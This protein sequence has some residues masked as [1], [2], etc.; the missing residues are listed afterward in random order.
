MRSTLLR[1][2]FSAIICLFLLISCTAETDQFEPLN[3]ENYTYSGVYLDISE[4]TENAR[5]TFW[6][7]DGSRIFVTG[8]FTENV[9]S[10]DLPEPW[11]LTGAVF[12][13][14]FDLSEEFG[15]TTGI[16][17]AHGLYFRED[18]LKKWVFNRTEIWAYTL[19][20]PWE[21]ASATV[22][23][24]F[25][26]S[27]FVLRGHDVDFNP[28]GTKIFIDDRNAQAVHEMHL[29]EPWDITSGTWH[30]TLDISDLEEEV[31]GIEIIADGRIML[32]LDTVRKEV[33]QYVMEVPYELETASFYSSLDVSGQSDDPRGLSIHPEYKH[34][35]ITGRDNQQI[36]QYSLTGQ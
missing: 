21:V 15:S 28:E 10:Y 2:Y 36:Y 17:R 25:D 12:T 9:A 30:Y 13:G 34:L 29:S 8:R 22:R 27:D 23:H 32:L 6:K 20:E 1:G 7:P 24:N 3:F 18:G 31:R 16:S 33:L 5:A 26:L 4:E 14:E 19:N 11:N 35:Y